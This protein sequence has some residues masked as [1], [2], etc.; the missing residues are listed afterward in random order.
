MAETVKITIEIAKDA[1]QEIF[2]PSKKTRRLEKPKKRLTVNTMGKF[3]KGDFILGS[4]L[5]LD[6]TGEHFPAREMPLEQSSV[7]IRISDSYLQVTVVDVQ[8]TWVTI[9]A[10]DHSV[11]VP[12]TKVFKAVRPRQP[13]ASAMC[14]PV[15]NQE[16]TNND[17]L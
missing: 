7:W 12:V 3:T 4:F 17:E 15:N 13:H 8:G 9:L 1:L 14:V 11:S 10:G 16:I 2:R 6:S 5:D